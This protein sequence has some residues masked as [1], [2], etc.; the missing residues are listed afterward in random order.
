V[1]GA[2]SQPEDVVAR[3]GDLSSVPLATF[4][5]FAPPAMSPGGKV[6]F[7]ARVKQTASPHSLR[8]VFAFE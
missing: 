8:G 5:D 6:A 4:F 7:A 3:T 2:C 1:P